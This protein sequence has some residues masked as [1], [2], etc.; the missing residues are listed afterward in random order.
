VIGNDDAERY[1][2]S[3]AMD[4]QSKAFFGISALLFAACTAGTIVWSASMSGMGGM[5]MPGGWTMSMTWMRLPGQ[6]WLGAAASFVAMWVVMMAAMMLPSLAPTLW[7]FRQAVAAADAGSNAHLGRL[8]A[9]AG[10]GY[11]FAWAVF[12]LFAF[13]LGVTLA[14]AVMRSPALARVVPI[15]V[16][17]L[18]LTAGALQL[19]AWK[20]HQLEC[21]REA[22]ARG[23]ELKPD[24][25]TAWR[26]GTRLG[27]RC[28]SC[29]FGLTAS[30]L[31]VGLM[32]LR[33]MLLVTAAVNIERMGGE[34]IARA[35]G[36]TAMAAGFVLI[37]RQA[38]LDYVCCWP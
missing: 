37:A 19:T 30:L 20:A 33:A 29:C 32:D 35:I 38:G 28:I 7:R 15:A 13:L 26:Y 34:R 9:V 27:M 22:P 17:A 16:G 12:G 4:S 21:C 3:R 25:G 2:L 31:V 5:P 11:F 10:A 23:R 1:A 36:A 18:V 14:G 8:T 6:G 24:A